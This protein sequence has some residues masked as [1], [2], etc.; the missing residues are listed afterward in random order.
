M[1]SLPIKLITRSAFLVLLV[2]VVKLVQ[3]DSYTDLLREDMGLRILDGSIERSGRISGKLRYENISDIEV[4]QIQAVLNTIHPGAI[5]NIGGVMEGCSCAETES[6][7]NQVSVVAYLPSHSVGITL[8]KIDNVWKVGKVQGWW[9][10]YEALF[11]SRRQRDNG[12]I[13]PA[14]GKSLEERIQDLHER[15]PICNYKVEDQ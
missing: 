15:M 12:F 10:E 5:V 8:S 9:L 14:T 2:T 3:A 7:T 1:E 11:R 4:R 6:C 13:V